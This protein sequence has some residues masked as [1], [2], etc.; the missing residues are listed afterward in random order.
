MKRDSAHWVSFIFFISK[1]RKNVTSTG[2]VS[3]FI[4]CVTLCKHELLTAIIKR[5]LV[6]IFCWIIWKLKIN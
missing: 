4:I 2:S 6:I 3:V 5:Q 1:Q